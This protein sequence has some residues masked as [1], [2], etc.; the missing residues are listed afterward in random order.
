MWTSE[1]TQLSVAVLK[2]ILVAKTN[3]NKSCNQLHSYLKT[4]PDILKQICSADKYK[5]SD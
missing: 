4:R 1:K 2:A 5:T 3:I